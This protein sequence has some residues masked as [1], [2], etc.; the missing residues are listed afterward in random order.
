MFSFLYFRY[1][2]IIL[3]G[4]DINTATTPA[5]IA[6]NLKTL[7]KEMKWCGIERVFFMSICQRGKFRDRSMTEVVYRKMKTSVN[8]K[9]RH[10]LKSDYVNGDMHIKYPQHFSGDGVHLN[11]SGLKKLKRVIFKTFKKTV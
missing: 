8:D 6:E 3:G 10:F 7:V 5:T 1:V 9:M 2:F 4:N 11:Q